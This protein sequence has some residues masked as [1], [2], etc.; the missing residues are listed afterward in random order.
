MSTE[1]RRFNLLAATLSVSLVVY[2]GGAVYALVA[3]DIGFEAFAA[4]VGGPLGV[5]T[6]WA[7]RGAMVPQP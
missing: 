6:G 5:M 7:G 3:L 2:L 1:N 4:A